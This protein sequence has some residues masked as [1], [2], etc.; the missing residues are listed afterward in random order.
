[1]WRVVFAGVALLMGASAQTAG[2]WTQW[3]DISDNVN[4]HDSELLEDIRRFYPTA[5]CEKPSDI[6]VQTVDGVALA[7]TGQAIHA[8]GPLIGFE[9]FDTDQAG[10]PFHIPCY[11]YE[12]RFFCLPG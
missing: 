6:Q 2:W 12:V 3:F 1:M 9:C 11:D 4:G 5:V 7:D 10:Y 8:M